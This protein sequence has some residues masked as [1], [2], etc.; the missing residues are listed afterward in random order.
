MSY[1]PRPKI[2]DFID[3]ISFWNPKKYLEVHQRQYTEAF[4]AIMPRL[5]K[6]LSSIPTT[7]EAR[8]QFMNGL[9]YEMVSS[10]IP[11]GKLHIDDFLRTTLTISSA[12]LNN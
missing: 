5:Q 7:V 12:P 2:Q 8:K 1:P 9:E 11:R 3:S 10:K 6:A 4:S